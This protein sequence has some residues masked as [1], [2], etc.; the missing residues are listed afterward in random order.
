MK[1]RR[2]PLAH[3]EQVHWTLFRHADVRRV[4]ADP[5]TFGSAVSRHLAVP[6]GMDP[7]EHTGWRRLVDR[8]FTPELVARYEPEC[9]R[10]AR[11]LVHT[12]SPAGEVEWMA[13]FAHDYA[14]HTLCAWVGW[15]AALHEP[16]REWM[17]R[18]QAAAR[19][20]DRDALAGAGGPLGHHRARDGL[21]QVDRAGDVGVDDVADGVPV[22][23]EEPLARVAGD[24]N[25]QGIRQD[26][27][28]PRDG[29]AIAA[30]KYLG[31]RVYVEVVTDARGYS[32]T[33]VEY[34]ITR[35]LSLLSSISTIGRESVNV[36]ISRDY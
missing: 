3:G 36:R 6:N 18:Q 34:Q 30:G 2:C 11:E 22:L 16:L 28:S 21:D 24:A 15:P 12:L 19:S 7:P 1:R 17:Q 25:H 9:R 26:G 4:L 20:A 5:D 32:A 33:L 14:L 27:G 13:Q 23:V 8:Y 35:W 29:T 31:R 10:I